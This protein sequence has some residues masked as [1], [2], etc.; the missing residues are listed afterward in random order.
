MK[1]EMRIVTMYIERRL[2]PG[3]RHTV[4]YIERRLTP[5]NRH[6]VQYIERRLTPGNRHTVQYIER[7]LTPGNR[8]TVQYIERRLTPGNRHTVQYIERRLTPGNRHT[9]QYI[10][11]RLTP[12]NRHTVQYIERR[13]T[14][15]N[16]HTVQYIERRLTPGNRHTVQYIERRL[17]PGNRHTYKM[18][19]WFVFCPTYV[20][21]VSE[22]LL[23]QYSQLLLQSVLRRNVDKM[24]DVDEKSTKDKPR[25]ETR[26]VRQIDRQTLVSQANRNRLILFTGMDGSKTSPV[27]R[28]EDYLK[29][30]GI[31]YE[32]ATKAAINIQLPQSECPMLFVGSC[33]RRVFRGHATR[34]GL[35]AKI[36]TGASKKHPQKTEGSGEPME[37]RAPVIQGPTIE[38]P[39]AAGEE[40]HVG[41]QEDVLKC[42]PKDS[43]TYKMY[44][45]SLVELQ[46]QT[47]L[48]QD[49]TLGS[50]TSESSPDTTE[51]RTISSLT[52]SPRGD[53]ELTTS[54]EEH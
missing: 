20:K 46:M 52:S 9:V 37:K 54:A 40:D 26:T 27:P 28:I 1:Q 48:K 15:G 32:E 10:E 50:P 18:M 51:S 12:G 8:H 5:G 2:T 49:Q 44:G 21:V 36:S 42:L 22:Q 19:T 39:M 14:P 6:T 41:D 16:R 29:Q 38:P 30:S 13:L 25:V 53:T 43:V 34:R 7:R 35:G 23:R 11:R 24:T 4:Q 3:N 47:Q 45:L 17:T 33:P 31:D